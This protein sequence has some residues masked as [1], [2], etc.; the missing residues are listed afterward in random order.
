[1]K[2][3]LTAALSGKLPEKVR[4]GPTA[5]EPDSAGDAG[6]PCLSDA[7]PDEAAT[8]QQ[9]PDF[10]SA[11]GSLPTASLLPDGSA[12]VSTWRLAKI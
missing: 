10:T 5:S 9:T 1:M 11:V 6:F 12:A 8:L 7:H 3:A 2:S 4:A